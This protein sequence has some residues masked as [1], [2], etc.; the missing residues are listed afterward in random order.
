MLVG[1]LLGP[2]LGFVLWL[3]LAGLAMLVWLVCQWMLAP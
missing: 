2:F 3:A 1:V